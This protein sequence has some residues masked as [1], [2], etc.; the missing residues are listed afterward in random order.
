MAVVLYILRIDCASLKVYTKTGAQISL[1]INKSITGTGF[2]PRP[3]KIKLFGL[4]TSSPAT[5]PQSRCCATHLYTAQWGCARYGEVLVRGVLHG[6]R[7]LP[8][9]PVAPL[10]PWLY[11]NISLGKCQYFFSSFLEKLFGSVLPSPA[12]CIPEP[13][14][15]WCTFIYRANRTPG[16]TGGFSWRGSYIALVG[17]PQRVAPSLPAIIY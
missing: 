4:P 5:P 1:A 10:S 14:G 6:S 17:Y 8:A 12:Q 3:L 15:C 9:P 2:I 16:G 13:D 11:I 7:G